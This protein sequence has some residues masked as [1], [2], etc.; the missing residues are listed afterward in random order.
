MDLDSYLRE[1]RSLV[2]EALERYVPE[3]RGPSQMLYKAMRYSLFAGGKRIRPILHLASVEAC[4][5]DP[6][7]CLGFACALEMVHTYSLIHDD[8][9]SM[10]DDELRRGRPT[11]HMIFGEAL[12]LLAG[13]ALLTEAF[14]VIFQ[15]AIAKKQDPSLVL[16][17]AW[18]LALAAGAEGMVAGQAVD[19][20]SEGK[21]VEPTLLGFIHSKKTGALI[22]ASVR[23]GAILCGAPDNLLERLSIYGEAL[24]LAF[25]IRDDLLNEEGDPAKLGKAVKTDKTRGKVTYPSIYGV[26]ESRKRLASLVEEAIEAIREM[27]SKAEPLREI[28]LY[29][30][31]RDH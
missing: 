27:D 22:R 4:E 28:A 16:K 26:E 19:I 17:A 12:A 15:E 3:P 25:Q 11:N 1:K 18:E 31:R 14:R 23:T 2:E 30:A 9:P 7:Q 5:G 13:D 21:T 29:V 10:D 6:R 8:L 20:M 24:G